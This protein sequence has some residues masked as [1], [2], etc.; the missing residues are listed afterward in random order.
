MDKDKKGLHSLDI[1]VAP[2][3]K[4]KRSFDKAHEILDEKIEKIGGKRDHSLPYGSQ[5]L[6]SFELP[7]LIKGHGNVPKANKH[8]DWELVKKILILQG[9]REDI[10]AV[11]GISVVSLIS[12]CQKDLGI[13]LTEL[14]KMGREVGRNNLRRVL[15]EAAVIDNNT[16]A[17]IWLSKNWLGMSDKQEVKIKIEEWST[18]WNTTPPII[19]VIDV[20]FE[21]I[22]ET[23]E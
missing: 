2:S 20:E 7:A 3:V 18:S 12:R 16:Q 8:I 22:P 23:K 1:E 4:K 19:D 10:A 5:D 15:Y 13:T 14:E 17:M 11:V 9:S 6:Y 21:E